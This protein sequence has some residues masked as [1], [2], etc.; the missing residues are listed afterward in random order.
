MAAEPYDQTYVVQSKSVQ[1]GLSNYIN[2]TFLDENVLTFSPSL[3]FSLSFKTQDGMVGE[4]TG[5]K[6]RKTV[7]KNLGCQS[8]VTSRQLPVVSRHSPAASRQSPAT[9]C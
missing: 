2:Q 3:F 1:P 4:M 7:N 9:I 6:P 5:Q 8:P